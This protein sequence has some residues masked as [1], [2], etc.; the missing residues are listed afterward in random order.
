MKSL[1]VLIATPT[2]TL[3]SGPA[4][5]LTVPGSEGDMTILANHVALVSTLR[6][7]VAVVKTKSDT[8]TFAIEKGVLEISDNQAS[9]LL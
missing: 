1:S 3:Y 2:E 8:K 6:K 4:E 7:G 5:S 9:V